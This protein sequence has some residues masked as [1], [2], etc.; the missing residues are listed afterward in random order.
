MIMCACLSVCNHFLCTKYVQKLCT[1]FDEMLWSGGAWPEKNRFDFGG[2]PDS[3]L[4]PGS[5]SGILYH[6]EIG[7]KGTFLQQAYIWLVAAVSVKEGNGETRLVTNQ[8]PTAPLCSLY[9]GWRSEK[10]ILEGAE[11]V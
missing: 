2:D 8:H 7:R 10:K 3:F 9:Q 6:Y 4:D 11:W 1:N 5:F